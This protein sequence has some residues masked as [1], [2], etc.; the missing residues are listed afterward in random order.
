MLLQL[1]FELLDYLVSIL[2]VYFGLIKTL[3]THKTEFLRYFEF[4]L[5]SLID[6]VE[7]CNT[8]PQKSRSLFQFVEGGRLEIQSSYAIYMA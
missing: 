6:Q 3:L 8:H 2:R 5:T 7:I 1:V 4:I